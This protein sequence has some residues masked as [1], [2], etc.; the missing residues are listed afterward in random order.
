MTSLVNAIH[1]RHV[2]GKWL[3]EIG[4]SNHFLHYC[5]VVHDILLNAF[6][7]KPDL[8]YHTHIFNILLKFR[9]TSKT[10]SI[11]SLL[12]LTKTWITFRDASWWIWI[13]IYSLNLM[14]S[15]II[16]VWLKSYSCVELC[17]KNGGLRKLFFIYACRRKFLNSI[18][19]C[20]NV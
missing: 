1:A 13:S 5:V 7:L 12:F 16:P 20:L 2:N 8:C 3:S 6:S 15:N 18:F 17:T 14:L 11:L 19:Y 10:I 9:F 4:S